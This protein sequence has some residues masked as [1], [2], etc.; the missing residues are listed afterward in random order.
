MTEE[1]WR[2]HVEKEACGGVLDEIQK[3]IISLIRTSTLLQS[4]NHNC[5]YHNE[6][7]ACEL[8]EKEAVRCDELERKLEE[9]FND[10]AKCLGMIAKE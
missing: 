3:T 9:G 10:L 1:S 4:H 6:V 2:K 5:S 7:Y 8:A